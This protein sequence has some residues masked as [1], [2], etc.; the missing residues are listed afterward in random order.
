MNETDE[1]TRSDF[2]K[3]LFKKSLGT[4][5]NLAGSLSVPLEHLAKLGGQWHEVSVAAIPDNQPKL[6]FCLGR[7]FFILRQGELVRAYSALC[8]NDSILMAIRPRGGFICTLC[9]EVFD[10]ATSQEKF[11]LEQIP[12][13]LDGEKV[14]LAL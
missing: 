14:F 10:P 7:P 3:S 6:V 9:G 13:R 8:P 11:R 12:A 2:F 1:I 4:A 5:W